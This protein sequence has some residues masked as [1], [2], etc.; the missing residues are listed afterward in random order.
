MTTDREQWRSATRAVLDEYVDQ[1]RFARAAQLAHSGRYLEAQGVLCVNG[2]LPEIPRDLDLLAR[3][4]VRQGHVSEARR[5]W[6]LALSK[7]PQNSTYQECLQRLGELPRIRI[8]FD[9]ALT[10]AIWVTN[11]LAITTLMYVFLLRK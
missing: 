8:P 4:A 5:L 2:Q 10:C 11:I 3:I 9:T 6:E 1:V 7:E